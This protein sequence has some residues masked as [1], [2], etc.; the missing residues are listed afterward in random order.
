M[1]PGTK[2]PKRGCPGRV[3]I[4][5]AR[6]PNRREGG[7]RCAKARTTSGVGSGTL[8]TTTGARNGANLAGRSVGVV[9]WRGRVPVRAN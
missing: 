9:N 3:G 6:N 1:G 5:P 8:W 2:E 7:I 4:T